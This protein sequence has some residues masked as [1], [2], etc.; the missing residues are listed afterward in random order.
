TGPTQSGA[1]WSAVPRIAL[2]MVTAALVAQSAEALRGLNYDKQNWQQIFSGNGNVTVT[3]PDGTKWTG[4]AWNSITS[5]V[6]DITSSLSG[7]AAKGANSDITSLSGLTTALSVAQGGTG[8][9]TASGA[10]TN[11]EL[12][13]SAT[14]NVGSNSGDVVTS[15][16][17]QPLYKTTLPAVGYNDIGDYGYK[18]TSTL[19]PDSVAKTTTTL[20][21]TSG[22]TLSVSY[23]IY[24]SSDN[25]PG[26][27]AHLLI[28]TDGVG[29]LRRYYFY[30]NGDIVGPSGKFYSEKNTTKAADGTLKA[31]SPVIK[32]FSDGRAETN[33]ESEGCIVTRLAV[34][35]YLVEGCNGL[36]SD[37]AWGGPDGGFDV[38]TDRNK[39]PLIWL[40]YEVNPDG[41]VLVKTYH[42]T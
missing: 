5:S 15:G 29:Y 12:G 6:N 42:R 19:T 33:A 35:E 16:S 27:A 23:G 24:N 10:R 2:N 8:S 20:V 34:G 32:L 7:K 21:Q 26:N 40:D 13:N 37:A 28:M 9:T 14:K 41:S 18:A 1:A 39:Q 36:N 3:L 38:P 4:L 17:T 22:W 11:L 31:A 30:N 25:S